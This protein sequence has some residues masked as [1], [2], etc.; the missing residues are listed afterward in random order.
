MHPRPAL[1]LANEASGQTEPNIETLDGSAYI[2]KLRYISLQC[3]V[4]ASN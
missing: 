3:N 1:A 4:M 2:T